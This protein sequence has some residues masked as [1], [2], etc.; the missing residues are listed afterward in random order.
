MAM[1]HLLIFHHAQVE[2]TINGWGVFLCFSFTLS[3]CFIQ[4]SP[5]PADNASVCFGDESRSYPY[6]LQKKRY[7]N[8]II[9]LIT[10]GFVFD[11]GD[12]CFVYLW[13]FTMSHAA[14]CSKYVTAEKKPAIFVS[15]TVRILL[16]F[17]F[18]TPLSSY[19]APGNN[20]SSDKFFPRPRL[21]S[22]TIFLTAPFNSPVSL[23][24]VCT[25]KSFVTHDERI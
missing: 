17:S 11:R 1:W 15:I 2:M 6:I 7:N 5:P 9:W 16:H 21:S 18:L 4:T 8:N 3:C 12:N 25:E 20:S 23:S 13:R 24:T 19:P 14:Q 10:A 22:S